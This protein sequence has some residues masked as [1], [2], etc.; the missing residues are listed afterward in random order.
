MLLEEKISQREK[1]GQV[2]RKTERWKIEKKKRKARARTGE[3]L[4][5]RAEIGVIDSLD[6]L[7]LV[8]REHLL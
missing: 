3:R 2:K 1:R 7:R 8:E 4:L 6:K 5:H